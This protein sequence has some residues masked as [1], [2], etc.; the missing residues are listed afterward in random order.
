MSDLSVGR[1]CPSFN[2]A[3]ASKLGSKQQEALRC[4]QQAKG[5]VAKFAKCTK[6]QIPSIKSQAA[7][8]KCVEKNQHNRDALA[9]C[10]ARSAIDSQ[11]TDEQRIALECAVQ[12]QGDRTKFASCVGSR[13]IKLTNEQQELVSCGAV[14]RDVSTFA[15]CAG[16]ALF[17]NNLSTDQRLVVECTVQAVNSNNIYAFAFCAGARYAGAYLNKE[18]QIAVQCTIQSNGNPKLAAIC[19][20]GRLA[21]E[22]LQTCYTQGFG[23]P[24][25]CFG[26]NN[27]ITK[28]YR[29]VA[30]MADSVINN[31]EL[32]TGGPNSV[33]NNPGQ[34]LGGPG[35]VFND[36]GQLTRNLPQLPRIELPKIQLRF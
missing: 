34:I 33:V 3:V 32:L 24:N 29:T 14:Y 12:A 21:A 6:D 7:I 8:V 20:A 19:T 36:P 9:K 11:L 16:V 10:A 4:A 15:V 26:D 28:V 27:E 25:G 1:E 31:P 18:Q 13:S 30:G 22:E 17:G 2:K 23:G 35:S 5:E